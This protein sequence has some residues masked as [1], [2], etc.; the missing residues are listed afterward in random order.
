[1][2]DETPAG[3]LQPVGHLLDAVHV[4]AD[5]PHPLDFPPDYPPEDEP[6]RKRGRPRNKVTSDGDR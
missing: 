3:G 4:V 6:K 1:V 5:D 2:R